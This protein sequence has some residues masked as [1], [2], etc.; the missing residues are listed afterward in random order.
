MACGRPV[1]GSAVGGIQH[2]VKDNVT[3]FLVP[4]RDPA[5]LASRLALLHEQPFLGNAFGLA[6]LRR[7]RSRFTWDIVARQLAGVYEELAEP[8]RAA[9][10]AFEVRSRVR[11]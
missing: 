7:V 6:G 3:G 4:P 9:A 2:S 8:R 11:P 10:A 5:A 1:I